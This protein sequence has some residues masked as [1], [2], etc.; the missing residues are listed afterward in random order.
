MNYTIKKITANETYVVRHPVLRAGKPLES[1]IFDG[2]NLDTTF[3]LGIYI[4]N[5]L[6]GVCSFFKSNNDLFSAEFQYQLR[7]MAVLDEFQNLGLGKL[8]L[9]H[10]ENLL[11]KQNIQIIW[12]NA[13]KKAI[14]FYSKNS[15]NIIGLPFD[16]KDIGPHYIMYKL[17]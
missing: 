12:C 4:E 13:R 16:I 6:V 2:D 17:L 7:G 10:G 14:N 9:I 5:K 1:C 11:K 3:H 8:I 15:Y